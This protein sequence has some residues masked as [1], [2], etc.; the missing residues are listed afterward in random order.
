MKEKREGEEGLVRE[1]RE[2]VREKRA[3]RKEKE[4]E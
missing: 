1:Q 2:R 4:R 3:G